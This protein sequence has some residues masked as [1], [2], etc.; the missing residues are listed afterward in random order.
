MPADFARESLPPLLDRQGRHY[1]YL[2]LSVTDRCDF[3]CVYCMPPSGED[4]HALRPDLL[5]F[6]EAARLVE[7]LARMGVD[8]VRFTGG[9]PLVR[10]D[11]VRLIELVRQRTGLT[12]LVMTTNGHRLAELARP[13]RDAGLSGVNISIDTL[14][15]ERFREI[16]R[17]GEL[18]RVL[19]GVHAAL[20]VGLEVKINAVALGGVNDVD[21]GALVDWAWDLG[22]TPRFIELMPLGEA[23]KLSA[24][25]FL[26]Q[27]ALIALLGERV[28]SEAEA[29][30]VHGQGPARYLPA[31]TRSGR[32]VGFITAVSNEFC[33]SCNRVRI[34]ARGEMRAC[35]ASRS[36]VSLRDRMR[37]GHSDRQLAWA[38]HNALST[39][40]AGH[41]FDDDNL[42]TDDPPSEHTHVGMSLVGG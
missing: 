2:R 13:L 19:S 37:Q 6:E 14:D 1:T 9:E 34:T 38:V 17:G 10:R 15:V 18:A 21:A 12:K 23:A 36:A 29:E 24:E 32:R 27:T 20:D 40:L 7:V 4:D 22:I 31:R 28:D 26:A 33:G 25:H 11:V 35:L 3:A 39:K 8:R 41:S 16:T 5:S 30:N 42:S